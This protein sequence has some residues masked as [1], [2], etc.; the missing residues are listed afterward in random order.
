MIPLTV[1]TIR[2]EAVACVQLSILFIFSRKC[3]RQEISLKRQNYTYRMVLFLFVEQFET[4][5]WQKLQLVDKSRPSELLLWWPDWVRTVLGEGRPDWCFQWKRPSI[6]A[7]LTIL[8][9]LDLN[10]KLNNCFSKSK[11]CCFIF[12]FVFSGWDCKLVFSIGD[13]HVIWVY[14]KA[15]LKQLNLF[16]TNSH[17]I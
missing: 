17:L 12:I 13:A 7:L 9:I 14:Q 2:A 15:L 4:F 3:K 5:F 8:F 6:E 11:S 16:W 10:W 1:I